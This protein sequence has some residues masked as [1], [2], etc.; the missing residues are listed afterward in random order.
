MRVRKCYPGRAI[1]VFSSEAKDFSRGAK[2]DEILFFPL[3]TK[4]TTCFLKNFIAICQIFTRPTST[5][6]PFDAH[7]CV[8]RPIE[9]CS[10]HFSRGGEKISREALQL[11][12][13]G[14]SIVNA[15]EFMSGISLRFKLHVQ[16]GDN[17]IQTCI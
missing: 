1:V 17:K 2:N 11:R 5:P 9:I 8:Y 13:C 14:Y 3:E 15:R 4:R 6:S 16:V 10:T 7:N 12:A